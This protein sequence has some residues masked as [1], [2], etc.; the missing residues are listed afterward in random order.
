VDT[1]RYR[2][3]I[4]LSYFGIANQRQC[5]IQKT[6]LSLIGARVQMSRKL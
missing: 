4:Q 1:C 2:A 5:C 3:K 6:Y